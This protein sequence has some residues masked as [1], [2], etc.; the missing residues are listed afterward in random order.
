[1]DTVTVYVIRLTLS[2]DTSDGIG[3]PRIVQ[4]DGRPGQLQMPLSKLPQWLAE[5]PGAMVVAIE[6]V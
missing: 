1:M 6:P 5:N 4:R 2:I 3:G